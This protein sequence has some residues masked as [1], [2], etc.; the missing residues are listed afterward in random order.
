MLPEMVDCVDAELEIIID[1]GIRRGTDVI[2]AIALG[3]K[4]CMIGRPYIYGLSAA[5]K[6]GVDKAL[7]ILHDEIVRDMQL[8]GCRSLS[9]LNHEFIRLDK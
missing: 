1:S 4:A 9:Q 2:K 3:A 5:G 7:A 8:L 6:A